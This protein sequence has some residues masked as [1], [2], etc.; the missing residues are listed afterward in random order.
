MTTT[1]SSLARRSATAAPMLRVA[2]VTIATFLFLH[3]RSPLMRILEAGRRKT[4]R[5][6][7]QHVAFR[8]ALLMVRPRCFGARGKQGALHTIAR[9]G[10]MP[11]APGGVVP[12]ETGDRGGGVPAGTM[13][14][15]PS[16]RMGP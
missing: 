11:F 13:A 14:F 8:S 2:P 4:G 9:S 10:D 16:V 1:K 5:P 7:L 6:A 15:M 3:D 12:N